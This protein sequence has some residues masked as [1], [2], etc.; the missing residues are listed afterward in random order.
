MSLDVLFTNLHRAL[1]LV[2]S[3]S[4]V[5]D[6]SQQQQHCTV[7]SITFTSNGV[8]IKVDGALS[9]NAM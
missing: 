7:S 8:Y 9:S 4:Y 1:L 3:R 2:G 6:T 5:G